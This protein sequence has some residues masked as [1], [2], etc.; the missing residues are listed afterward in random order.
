LAQAIGEQGRGRFADTYGSLIVDNPRG[1]VSLCVTD[2]ARGRLLAR[3]AKVAAPG[4]DLA[5]LDIYSCRYA[6]RTVDAVL[7]RLTASGAPTFAYPVY[8]WAFRP[9]AS[10]IE[11]T[12]TV[13]GAAS[14]K[15]HAALLAATGGIPVT[16][17]VGGLVVPG[18]L[19][20]TH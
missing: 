10:G 11:V 15:F 20:Q 16:L 6:Q 18:D 17:G 4:I 12:T 1:R 7:A 8:S 9:D 5:R 3:A 14:A 13:E 2:L 19:V